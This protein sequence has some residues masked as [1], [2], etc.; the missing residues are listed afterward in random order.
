MKIAKENAGRDT[1]VIR[2]YAPGCINVS[3]VLLTRSFIVAP[4]QLVEDW[5]PQRFEELSAEHLKA[6]LAL[7]P[8]ILIIGTGKQQHFLSGEMMATLGKGGIGVE[9]MDTAAA[10][11]TYNVLLS[12]DRKVVAA[13]LMI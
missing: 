6:A 7:D 11:R 4:D 3:D 8:E 1:K 10:C 9:V 2:A 12:E 13:L 5:P